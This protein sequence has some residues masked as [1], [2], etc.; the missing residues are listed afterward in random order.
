[1]MINI[2]IYLYIYILVGGFKNYDTSL[3]KL[4]LEENHHDHQI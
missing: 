1:M 4:Y 3:T 2:Y